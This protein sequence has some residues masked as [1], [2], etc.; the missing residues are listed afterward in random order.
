MATLVA[1][2]LPG[3]PG[4]ER[5]IKRVWDAGDAI[6]PVDPRLPDGER[7]RVL[8]VLRPGAVIGPDGHRVAMPDGVPVD[9][10]DALVIATSGTS[11]QPKAVIHT[12][13]SVAASANATSAALA[14]D[15]AADRWVACLPLAHIGG[16]SVVLRSIVTGTPVEI[17]D[18]FDAATV[19]AAARD[20]GATLVSLVTR[21]LAQVPADAFRTVLIGGAAPPADRP[22]NVVATYGMTETGSG[23]VYRDPGGP[24]RLLDGLDASIGP[25]DAPVVPGGEGEIHLRGPMLFRGYRFLDDPFVDGWFP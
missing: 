10:G 19:L 16:L 25:P 21:A 11:G 12:H 2:T 22:P 24:S 3:G 6:A 7:R 4:Y 15:P 14:V 18:R 8:D 13:D 9:D 17:H 23:V 5:A 1:L 20:R